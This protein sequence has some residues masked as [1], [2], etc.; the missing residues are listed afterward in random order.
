MDITRIYQGAREALRPACIRCLR[1]IVWEV[2]GWLAAGK[3][4]NQIIEDYPELGSDDFRA[5]YGYAAQ[6]GHRVAL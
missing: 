4:E 6:M 5:V 1:I 2:L 3:T